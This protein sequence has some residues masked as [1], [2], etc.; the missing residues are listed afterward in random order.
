M[1]RS[2]TPSDQL[3]GGRLPRCL[4]PIS[5]RTT[6]TDPDPRFSFANERTFLAWNRT[7]LALVGAGLVV[8]QFV[9][10]GP[11]GSRTA[12]SVLLILLGT[13]VSAGSYHHWYRCERALR[14][15][16]PLPDSR[17]LLLV[18]S[19]GIA[20]VGAATVTIIVGA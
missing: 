16:Q 17:L 15:G 7:G 19:S 2:V 12:L 11:R 8:H 9:T 13:I 5:L 20:L 4:R 14:R 1:R 10:T 3:G 6:G 18:L